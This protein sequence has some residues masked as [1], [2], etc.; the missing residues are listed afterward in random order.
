V[1]LVSRLTVTPAMSSVWPVQVAPLDPSISR[2]NA[3]IVRSVYASFNGLAQSGSVE[4]YVETHF[5]ADCEYRPIE[6]AGP[7]RGHGAITRWV[8]RWFEA[9]EDAWDEIVEVIASGR[10]VVAAIRVHGRGRKSG[11]EISQPL[12]DVHEIRDGRVMRI[13]EYLTREQALEAAGL[14]FRTTPELAREGIARSRAFAL[15]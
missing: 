13:R 4:S 3:A 5:D 10:M 15:A 12:F 9:W 1:N 11:M 8:E 14:P 7:L 6:E 2:E